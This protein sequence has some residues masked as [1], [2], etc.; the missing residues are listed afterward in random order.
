MN[1]P[2]Q[3]NGSRT[4]GSLT[5]E[6]I[7]SLSVFLLSLFF[8]FVLSRTL[9]HSHTYTIFSPL[10]RAHMHTLSYHIY[11]SH[12]THLDTYIRR[13]TRADKEHLLARTMRLYGRPL[14][15]LSLV[16][17]TPLLLLTTCD[18]LISH[19]QSHTH[20]HSPLFCLYSW[21]QAS[22]SPPCF[23][24]PWLCSSVSPSQSPTTP[25]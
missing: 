25:S 2:Y 7:N 4:T 3:L 16:T 15:C 13:S 19:M 10:S 9:A 11:I 8:F 14:C 18:S 24:W 20:K 22:S 23:R 1:E 6:C 21:D 12:N 5:N 17:H